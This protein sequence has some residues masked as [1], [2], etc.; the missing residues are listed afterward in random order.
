M[1]K[2]GHGRKGG[3]GKYGGYGKGGSGGYYDGGY[4]YKGKKGLDDYWDFWEDDDEWERQNRG[5]SQQRRQDWRP[6]WVQLRNEERAALR[7]GEETAAQL[8]N[9]RSEESSVQRHGEETAAQLLNA[10]N[11]EEQ[12]EQRRRATKS[13]LFREEKQ[14]K[15]VK[16]EL[17]AAE[18]ME[19]GESRVQEKL[20]AAELM[21]EAADFAKEALQEELQASDFAKEGVQEELQA[22]TLA[23]ERCEASE[24][25]MAEKLERLETEMRELR[26]VVPMSAGL[27]PFGLTQAPTLPAAAAAAGPCF[28]GGVPQELSV[29]VIVISH[30]KWALAGASP[31]TINATGQLRTTL[32]A[33]DR[34]RPVTPP[35]KARDLWPFKLEET[36]PWPG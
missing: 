32:D 13:K 36:P 14:M 8:L 10:R 33:V 29:N 6:E 34:R 22:A 15:A 23:E 12:N 18:L 1:G 31:D 4:G 28:I 3:Y 25:R 5:W 20:A 21:K 35:K 26:V 30:Q 11:T 19:T 16:E 2:G 24:I 7:N 17:A 27:P 9:A